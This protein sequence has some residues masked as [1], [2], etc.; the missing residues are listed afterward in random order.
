MARSCV[1]FSG[2]SLVWNVVKLIISKGWLL[3]L[4]ISSLGYS[5]QLVDRIVAIVDE[6]P[7]LMSE[8][9][10]KV[11]NGPLV[12][13]S[14]YPAVADAPDFDKALQDSINFQLMVA[15]AEDLEIEVEDA[16]VEEQI[17]RILQNQKVN[18]DQ[19]KLFL[20]QQN[21][22]YEDY[23]NDLRNQ[24][25]LRRFQGRVILP[26]VKVTEQQ[27][28]AYYLEKSGSTAEAAAVDLEQ[29]FVRLPSS[30]PEGL[31]QAKKAVIDGAYEKLSSGMDFGE[32][33]S[34]FG[35]DGKVSTMTSVKVNDL[36][37]M[38]KA[39]VSSLQEG[40]FSEPVK[41]TMGFHIFR[42]AKRE[43]SGDSKYVQEKRQLEYELRVRET[44]AQ[45]K[46]WLETE[47]Q[48]TKIQVIN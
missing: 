28:K 6:E 31:A 8:I 39:A 20:E 2:S 25:L 48:K 46:R 9:N 26:L 12:S 32:V 7:I 10:E 42:V 45:L 41:T 13:V 35:D 36:A 43:L 27:V 19:L 5:Q 44:T 18:R 16:D 23:K 33:A 3:S 22:S 24:I 37:P 15:A 47:R 14:E 34:L 38:I 4:A 21:K 29:I 30:A 17:E 11:K 40:Q 1:K